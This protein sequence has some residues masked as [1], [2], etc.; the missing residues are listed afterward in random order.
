MKCFFGKC[1]IV[2]AIGLATFL[3]FWMQPLVREFD[4]S[5]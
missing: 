1:G 3:L 4:T 5:F 2:P